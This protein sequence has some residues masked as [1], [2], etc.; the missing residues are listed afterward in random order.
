MIRFPRGNQP[1]RLL[2]IMTAAFLISGA[3]S[4]TAANSF[5]QARKQTVILAV[6][7]ESREGSL[8]AIGILDAKKL[9]APYNDEQKHRQTAFA[10]DYFKKGTVYRLIF[11]GGDAGS[12]TVSK[13]SEGCNNVHAQ[14]TVSTSARLGGKVMALAT[15]SET[16]GK[17]AI[18]RRPPTDAERAATLTLMKRI[19]Q[20]NR[21]PAT[22]MP[23]IKVTNLTASDLNGD[24]Q[25][26]II[27]SFT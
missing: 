15:N 10:N 9:R 20:Q 19:Y 24:G 11:G 1:S 22:L 23:S 3:L 26:E 7:S 8:D 12:A 21:T 6:Q 13:W 2:S 5:A 17:H 14:A 16:L 18:S 27:G 4:G 25:Y